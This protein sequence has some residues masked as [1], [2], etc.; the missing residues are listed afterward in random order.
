MIEH[1]SGD[2]LLRSSVRVLKDVQVKGG[3]CLAAPPGHR[4][5]YIYPRDNA[6]CIQG[7]A[8]AGLFQDKHEECWAV[9][10]DHD[11]R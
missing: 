4:Y 10:K 6:V 2:A 11:H 5:P 3:G 7:F 8:S 9:R 1:K